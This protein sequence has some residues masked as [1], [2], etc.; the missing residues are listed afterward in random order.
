MQKPKKSVGV[1][2]IILV[3][4]AV[5]LVTFTVIMIRTFWL[6]GAIPDTLCT[7]VFGVLGTECGAMAWIKTNKDKHRDRKYELEDREYYEKQNGGTTMDDKKTEVTEEITEFP[8]QDTFNS[9]DMT[10]EDDKEAE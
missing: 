3:I 2:N 4:I 10:S 1:M 7:C 5:T 8:T 9:E 6:Y